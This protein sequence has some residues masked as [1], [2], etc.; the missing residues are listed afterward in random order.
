MGDTRYT[1]PFHE[2]SLH[3]GRP[4]RHRVSTRSP[5]GASSPAPLKH[6]APPPAPRPPGFRE[7]L[8]AA[9]V[10]RSSERSLCPAASRQRHPATERPRGPGSTQVCSQA[11]SYRAFARRPS[12]RSDQAA[13]P[14]GV[15]RC[16]PRYGTPSSATQTE[17]APP[18]TATL[19]PHALTLRRRRT[20]RQATRVRAL[21]AT[22]D[23][24]LPL[25]PAAL[26]SLSSHSSCL[27]GARETQ[28]LRTT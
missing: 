11:K 22:R 17:S 28:I 2:I 15:G 5:R 19:R 16:H 6:P 12:F 14:G 27:S 13:D 20:I 25:T 8:L 18:Q 3:L 1:A 7:T 23:T 26:P 10:P 21:K 4:C 24:S 9:S